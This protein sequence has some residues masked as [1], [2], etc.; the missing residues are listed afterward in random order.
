MPN[1]NFVSGVYCILNEDQ[2]KHCDFVNN[3]F[4]AVSRDR[5]R[6]PRGGAEGA[7]RAA[8]RHEDAPDVP[9]RVQA[10]REQVADRREAAQQGLSINWQFKY[11]HFG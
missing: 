5:V 2:N 6:D 1:C 7:A 3:C 4:L 8:H 10:G 11:T 9:V